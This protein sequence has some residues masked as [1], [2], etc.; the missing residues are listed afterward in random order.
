[1]SVEYQE[2]LFISITEDTMSDEKVRVADTSPVG[3]ELEAGKGA[4]CA[5]VDDLNPPVL[6][7]FQ[8]AKHSLPQQAVPKA[9]LAGA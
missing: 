5:A 6:E 7:L 2:P 4:T 9:R 3:V 1:M 8:P